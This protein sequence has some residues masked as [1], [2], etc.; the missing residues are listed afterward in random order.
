MAALATQYLAGRRED[1]R[2]ALLTARDEQ[3]VEQQFRH[4]RRLREDEATRTAVDQALAAALRMEEAMRE[5][6]RRR[7]AFDR[8][9]EVLNVE[10]GASV[11]EANAIARHD[12][13]MQAASRVYESTLETTLVRSRLAVCLGPGHPL[14]TAF[15]TLCLAALAVPHV[16]DPPEPVEDPPE[17]VDPTQPSVIDQITTFARLA[18]EWAARPAE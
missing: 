3:R 11:N 6:A 4:E 5:H 17:P 2:A 7:A 10:P 13:V 16:E 1:Q 9:I 14:S 15:L 18:H 12:L 8:A